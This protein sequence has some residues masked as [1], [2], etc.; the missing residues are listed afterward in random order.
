[1]AAIARSANRGCARNGRRRPGRA[2]TALL[3]LLAS[4]SS[5]GQAREV[6]T[7]DVPYVPTPYEVVERMLEMAALKPDDHLIDLGSGD[8]RIVIAAVRDWN[9]RSALGIDLDPARVAEAKANARMAGISDRATFVQG[10]LFQKSISDATVLT[11]YL[12]P[13]VNLRLRPVVLGAMEPGTRVVSHA[14]DMGDWEA[15]QRVTVGVSRIYLWIVP[16]HVAGQWLLTTADGT[17]VELSFTQK[18]QRI[19]GSARM[20]GVAVALQ[21]ASLRGDRVHFTVSG[22]RYMGRIE[23]NRIVPT[24]DSG[25]TRGWHA[26]RI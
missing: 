9:V 11:L 6:L 19:Q 21:D 20:N 16:A 26:Q 18:Y 22:E 17:R 8:G 24:E 4:V 14:F 10:D 7:L 1:M 2:V 23:G 13:E 3:L 5:G 15:D 12:Y 25:A